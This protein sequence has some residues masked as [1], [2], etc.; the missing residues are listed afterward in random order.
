MD[1]IENNFP[2]QALNRPTEGEVLLHL[3]LANIEEI[4]KEVKVGGSQ[5]SECALIKSVIL[6]KVGLVKSGV[7]TLNFR[8]F[9][10]VLNEIPWGNVL[11]NKITKQSWQHF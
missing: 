9:K 11:R 1:C 10:E 5:H 7:R 2:V 8:M 4:I 3:V 6:R